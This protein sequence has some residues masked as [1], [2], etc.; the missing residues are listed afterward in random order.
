MHM[1]MPLLLLTVNKLARQATWLKSSCSVFYPSL[2]ISVTFTFKKREVFHIFFYCLICYLSSEIFLYSELCSVVPVAA[3]E[4]CYLPRDKI[5]LSEQEQELLKL[6]SLKPVWFFPCCC[7]RKL[8]YDKCSQFF[9]FLKK[10]HPTSRISAFMI[11]HIDP[12]PAEPL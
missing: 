10:H 3:Y 5:Q 4:F 6:F 2:Y 11:N 9:F 8:L 7:T 12:Y 1:L